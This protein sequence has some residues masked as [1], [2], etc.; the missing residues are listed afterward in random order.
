MP[1]TDKLR[2]A[3]RLQYKRAVLWTHARRGDLVCRLMLHEHL[4][5]P[6]PL[7][8][9]IRAVGP[10]YRSRAGVRAVTAHELCGQVLRDSAFGRRNEDAGTEEPEADGPPDAADAPGGGGNASFLDGEVAD[11]MR[12]RR[13]VAPAFRT[14]KIAEYRHRTEEVAHRLLDAALDRG[15]DFDLVRDFAS[16]LPITVI[17]ELLGITDV[18]VERFAHYGLV[19]GRAIDGVRSVR[20]ATEFR[21]AAG[22]LDAIF[23]A[24][25]RRRRD[26]PGD[27]LVSDLLRPQGDERLPEQEIIGTCQLLLTAG[28]ETTTNLVSNAVL[29]LLSDR[30]QWE[31]LVAD[32]ELAPAVA[33]ESLRYDPPVQYSIRV[34]RD[35]MD[36]GGVPL[37]SGTVLMLVLGAANRDPDVFPDP[38]RFD[39]T[40]SDAGQHLAFLSGA[41]YCVGAPLARMEADVAL[42]VLAERLPELRRAGRLRRRPTAALRGLLNLPVSSGR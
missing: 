39:I 36:L 34:V 3:A 6:Y 21:E 35:A 10:V 16:P 22:E 42:S 9:G 14:R 37:P 20:Q 25:V 24:L 2:S 28:F 31:A 41:H 18:D 38:H 27:D 26:E 29:R 23:T 17:S 8:E 7:Y 30:E 12:W 5:D 1:N 32:P 15:G 19:T 13:L 4:A 40:R 11:H 33:E